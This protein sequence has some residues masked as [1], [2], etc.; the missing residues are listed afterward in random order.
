MGY[1]TPK[2]NQGVNFDAKPRKIE[3]L[4]KQFIIDVACGDSH[5]IALTNDRDVFMWGSNKRNQLGF[6][7]EYYPHIHT[8]RKLVLNEYMNSASKE[9]FAQ[10]FAKADYTVLVSRSKHIYITDKNGEGFL[11]IF[12]KTPGNFHFKKLDNSVYLAKDYIL[13]MDAL[14]GIYRFEVGGNNKQSQKFLQDKRIAIEIYSNSNF[15]E[16]HP[17]D[18]DIWA[19]NSMRQLYVCRDFKSNL[20]KNDQSMSQ[21]AFEP[22]NDISNVMKAAIGNKHQAIIKMVKKLDHDIM[23]RA[24]PEKFS[25]STDLS[26]L[27][28]DELSKSI[29]LDNCIELLEFADLYQVDEL[30]INCIKFIMLNMVS[31]FSEGTKLSEKLLALP[32]YLVR[33]IENFLKVKDIQKFL[34]LD[35][36]YFEIDIDYS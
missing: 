22:L 31:F 21:L 8:P 23:I 4:S 7:V 32:I 1:N 2:K 28:V 10:V 18:K 34:W 11:P 9:V 5:S 13:L 12:G 29:T 17:T 25:E 36:S 24:I 30:K 27:C 19:V 16:L 3:A 35:M 15:I 6:D 26:N 33:D 14:K 20:S